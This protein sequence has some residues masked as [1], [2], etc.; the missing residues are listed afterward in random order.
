MKIKL[1]AE[2]INGV[3]DVHLHFGDSCPECKIVL[4][5]TDKYSDYGSYIGELQEDGFVLS[6]AECGAEFQLVEAVGDLDEWEWKQ[7][8][9]KVEVRSVRR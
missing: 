7:T 3:G 8:K 9:G 5:A 2:S 6:C 4:A 1:T